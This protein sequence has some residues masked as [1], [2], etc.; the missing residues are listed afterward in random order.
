MPITSL[1]LEQFRSYETLSLKVPV[2]GLRVVGPNASGKT[3]LLEAVLFLATMRSPR[4]SSEGDLIRWTSGTEYGVAPFARVV[5]EIGTPE[6]QQELVVS[7]QADP[8]TGNA[9]KRVSVNGRPRRVLD[10]VGILQAVSFSPEDVS[11]LAGAPANRRR[12]IDVLLSQIDRGYLRSLS[13]YGRVLSQRN[14]LLRSLSRERA[15]PSAARTR[16]ELAFWDD[17]MVAAGSATVARRIACLRRIKQCAGSRH[18]RLAGGPLSVTY[19][20]NVVLEGHRQQTDDAP[21]EQL[22]SIVARDWT[23]RLEGVR[24]EELRRGVTLLGP[25]RDDFTVHAAE[26]DIGVYGSRGQQ[27]LAVVALK[28]AEADVM[29][30]ESGAPPTVLLDDVFSELDDAHA[31]QLIDA[32]SELGCQLLVTTTDRE[33]V[34]SPALDALPWFE[35]QMSS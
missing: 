34:T 4:S 6:D 2:E 3:T 31:T 30:E 14:G 28:L 15:S 26:V 18:S 22:A 7:L 16:S 17:E 19:Q 11:L 1:K 25:Q 32:L 12:Y 29:E 10:A 20:S 24:A 27:R 33:R 21:L 8:V 35:T 5:G 9:K 23:E 13:R